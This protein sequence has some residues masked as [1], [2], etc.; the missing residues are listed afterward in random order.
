M[1][2]REEFQ[3][4]AHAALSGDEGLATLKVSGDDGAIRYSVDPG[5]LP[6]KL[7]KTEYHPRPSFRREDVVCLLAETLWSRWTRFDANN[8]QLCLPTRDELYGL[9]DHYDTCR[10]PLDCGGGWY[11]LLNAVFRMAAQAGAKDWW[12]YDVKEKFGGLRIAYSAGPGL[13]PESL[14]RLDR[15]VD[16][17]EHLS[18][19]ICEECGAPGQIRDGGWIRTLCD[20]HAGGGDPRQALVPRELPDFIKKAPEDDD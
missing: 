20:V 7:A 1:N 14:A 13:T 6:S 16:A 5:E 10:S 9:R 4:I 19:H 8:G 15:I 11:D 3:T 18:E 17:A 12:T 2:A